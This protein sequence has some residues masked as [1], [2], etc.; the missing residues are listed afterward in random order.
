MMT[1]SERTAIIRSGLDHPF[2]RE[3]LQPMIAARSLQM[4]NN[5]AAKSTDDDDINRGWIQALS[6]IVRL[7]QTE[8]DAMNRAEHAA[9]SEDEERRQDAYRAEFGF[10]SPYRQS[11]EV[12][13]TSTQQ[14]EPPTAQATG[15]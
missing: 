13:E 15:E 2:W 7:P 4:L 1:D 11:P 14:P 3:W 9:Q 5:L 8:L 6:W 12:G 10:R